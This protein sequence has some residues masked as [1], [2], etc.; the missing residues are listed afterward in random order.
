VT[1]VVKRT[2]VIVLLACLTERV[3]RAQERSPSDSRVLPIAKWLEAGERVEIP[4]RVN[5]RPVTLRMDQRLEVVCEVRIAA[6]SLNSSGTSHQLVLVSRISGLD[7]RWLNEP[8]VV[9]QPIDSEIPKNM[10]A[11]FL[12]RVALKPGDFYIWLILYDDTTGKHNLTKRRLKIPEI[13]RDPLPGSDSRMPPA[14]FPEP[15]EAG[16][17][18]GY[19][20][21]LYLPVDNDRPLRVEIISTLSDPEQWSTVG[22]LPQRNRFN[23]RR[24]HAPNIVGALTALSQ[25]EL[26]RGSL[27]ITGLDLVRRQLAFHQEAPRRLDWKSLLAAIRKATGP[28]LNVTALAGRKNNGAFFRDYLSERITAAGSP[29]DATRVFI[30]LSE[31]LIFSRGADLKPLQ[32][33]GDCRCVI[34]HLRFLTNVQDTF[35]DLGKFIRPLRPR[36]FNVV[37]ALEL[38]K[39]IAQ[40][41]SELKTM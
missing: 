17:P 6:K 38:R 12:M 14:E 4:W 8:R 33:E 10:E 24:N 27:S 21:K 19:P 41:I 29:D 32:L 31:S 30:V 26:T 37:D 40:I 2:I 22:V 3:S 18:V 34:Y 16:A 25:M 7:G 13:H 28:E 1:A 11:L 9:R 36:A 15:R 20:S 35:D 5:V 39:A 23:P